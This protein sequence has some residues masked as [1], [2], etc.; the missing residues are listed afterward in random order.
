MF[1]NPWLQFLEH[2]LFEN[3]GAGKL[4][5]MTPNRRWM[6]ALNS[7]PVIMLFEV[8]REVTTHIELILYTVPKPGIKLRVFKLPNFGLREM[9]CYKVSDR[10]ASIRMLLN[11]VRLTP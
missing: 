8:R 7:T 9:V 4:H 6:N 3:L 5:W 11:D 2:T 10:K 1:S